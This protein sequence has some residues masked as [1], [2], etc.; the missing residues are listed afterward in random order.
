ML[1]EEVVSTV[2]KE[3]SPAR[4]DVERNASAVIF[5]IFITIFGNILEFFI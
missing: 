1:Q 5:Y 4:P 3:A 2:D